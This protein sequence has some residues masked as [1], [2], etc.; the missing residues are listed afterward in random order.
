[1]D[2]A[3]TREDEAFRD[4]YRGWLDEHLPAFLEEWSDEEGADPGS[5]DAAERSGA[6]GS[7]GSGS[8]R[9]GDE[10]AT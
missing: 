8:R 4:E 6:A 2:F 5:G 10:G 7:A 3:H 9:G 1:M